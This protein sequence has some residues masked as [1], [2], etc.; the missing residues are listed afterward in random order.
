MTVKGIVDSV[1]KLLEISVTCVWPVTLLL[2]LFVFRRQITGMLPRLE[3]RLKKAEIAGTKLEFSEVAV[4]A[5]KEAIETGA[6]E[7]KDDPEQ[8]VVFVREQVNKLPKQQL[9]YPQPGALTLSGHSILWVDDN[10]INN[11]YESSILKRLGAS[12][13]TARSTEEALALLNIDSYDLI[14]SDIHRMESGRENPAA[15]YDLLDAVMQ[16]EP[17][18]TLVFYTASVARVNSSRTSAAYGVADNPT[19]L[20]NLVAQALGVG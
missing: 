14:I 12:I 4:D 1:L 8:L 18:S 7:Y 11:T 5:L 20:L 13:V 17:D 3:Q 9:A 6:E 10:P 15:G 2:L 16:R 19:Q